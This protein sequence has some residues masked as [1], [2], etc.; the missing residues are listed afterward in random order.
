MDGNLWQQYT[1]NEETG[2]MH[3]FFSVFAV[4]FPGNQELTLEWST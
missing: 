1:F 4:F 3:N 2:E